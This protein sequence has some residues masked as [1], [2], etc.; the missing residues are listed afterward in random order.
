MKCLLE[1]II[2][3]QN[4]DNGANI[5]CP[6]GMGGNAMHSLILYSYGLIGSLEDILE[7]ATIIMEA[8]IDMDANQS[9]W[10]YPP[11]TPDEDMGKIATRKCVTAER[12]EDYIDQRIVFPMISS[13]LKKCIEDFRKKE[14]KRVN[15]GGGGGR[16]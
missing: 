4:V 16:P 2:R 15:G 13:S 3:I 7:I 9:Y 14:K 5:N 11:G 1:F 12:Y 6:N 10:G 8:G